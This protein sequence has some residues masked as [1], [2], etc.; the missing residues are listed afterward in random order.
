MTIGISYNRTAPDGR[1]IL[2]TPRRQAELEYYRSLEEIGYT[3][4]EPVRVFSFA[5]S[6]CIHCE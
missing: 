1:T 5:D 2:V 4:K 3:Y 6:A